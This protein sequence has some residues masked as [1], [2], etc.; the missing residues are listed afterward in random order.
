MA[1]LLNLLLNLCASDTYTTHDPRTEKLTNLVSALSYA[2]CASAFISRSS[3]VPD[4]CCI[5][6]HS[7]RGR[8]FC[9]HKNVHVSRRINVLA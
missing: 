3:S 6:C 7:L 5:R 2:R 8:I 9:M 1:I 4:Q